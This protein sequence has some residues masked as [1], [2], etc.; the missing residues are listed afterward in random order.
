MTGEL[1]EQIK[2][3]YDSS[4]EMKEISRRLNIPLGYIRRLLS[5]TKLRRS[6]KGAQKIIGTL[7]EIWPS[8]R[9]IEEYPLER[10]YIDIYIPELRVAIEFDGEFHYNNT[11]RNNSLLHQMELDDLK[12]LNC[13]RAGISLLRVSY[14]DIKKLTPA[15]LKEQIFSVINQR[16]NYEE[17]NSGPQSPGTFSSKT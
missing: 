6:S 9:I 11:W 15:V 4:I 7:R 16:G 10:Q 2:L 5:K 17:G 14:K 12:D 1:D 8:L 13:Q 3:L